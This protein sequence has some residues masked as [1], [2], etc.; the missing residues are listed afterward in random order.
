MN[1]VPFDIALIEKGYKVQT[2][3]GR[4]VT[5][6]HVFKS[7]KGDYSVAAVVS[8]E[9]ETFTKDGIFDTLSMRP[10]HIDLVMIPPVVEKWINVYPGPFAPCDSLEDA[11]KY[12]DPS[13][14]GFTIKA[15]Y[16]N[17]EIVKVELVKI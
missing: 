5:E 14:N 2:R 6:V 7:A 11:K 8:D 9:V 17:D 12:K 13:H 10:G 1:T 16:Q 15:T 4:E 3:D